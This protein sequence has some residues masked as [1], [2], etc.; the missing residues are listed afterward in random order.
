MERILDVDL[1]GREQGLFFHK[2]TLLVWQDGSWAGQVETPLGTL[3]LVITP[4]AVAA[5]I[6]E[7]QPAVKALA[8]EAAA[9]SSSKRSPSA[10][11]VSAEAPAPA[12]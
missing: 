4:P 8:P 7:A 9:P 3:C 12:E 5:P 10:S 2:Q 1:T 6:A 11:Q